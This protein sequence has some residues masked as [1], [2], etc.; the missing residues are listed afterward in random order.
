[1]LRCTK[2]ETCFYYNKKHKSQADSLIQ[3]SYCMANYKK[4]ACYIASEQISDNQLP[5]NLNPY[6]MDLLS[7][8]I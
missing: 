5:L 6:D 1:M 7:Q 8:I 3:L 4:C 2:A